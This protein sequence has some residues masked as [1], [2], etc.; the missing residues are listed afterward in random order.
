MVT[1]AV[2]AVAVTRAGAPQKYATTTITTPPAASGCSG[3]SMS[4]AW[5]P[6]CSS[7]IATVTAP[8]TT[9]MNKVFQTSRVTRTSAI[10]TRALAI[11]TGTLRPARPWSCAGAGVSVVMAGPAGGDECSHL[12]QLGLLVLEQLVDGVGVLLGRRVQA[13]LRTGHVVLTDLAV[14]LHPL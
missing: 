2:T 12:E 8:A 4:R 10:R 6:R 9:T 14:L 7:Q 11:E 5:N 13:L 3:R 1:R